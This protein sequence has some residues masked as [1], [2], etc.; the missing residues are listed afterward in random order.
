MIIKRIKVNNY[1]TYLS[2]DLDLSV[3]PDK[4][5]ILIGGDNGGGK[6][7]LF[8]A[9]CGALYGLKIKDRR[10]FN[11]LLNDGGRGKVE[12]KIDLEL[13]FEGIVLGR[14][15]PYVLRRHYEV[16]PSG[17]VVENVRMNMN[18]NVY[19]YG[20][21]TP[22]AERRRNE[23]E[24]SKIIKGNL[25]QELSRYFLFDAMQ[26]SELLKENAFA[27]TIKDNIENV[28]GFNKYL[29]MKRSAEHLL[30]EKTKERLAA[31]E[32]R[33]EYEKLCNSRREL[34]A[35]LKETGE[36]L[37]KQYRY[38]ADMKEA[39]DSAKE[40]ADLIRTNLNE[41]QRIKDQIGATQKQAEA[42]ADGLSAF[43]QHM[44]VN[45]ILP[46]VADSMQ[47]E[48][49]RLIKMKEEVEED[50][51]HVYSLED[52]MTIAGKVV[53]YLKDN[54]GFTL[55]VDLKAMSNQVVSSQRQVL[56]KDEYAYLDKS[57]ANALA[58]LLGNKAINDFVQL[59]K[60]RQTLE[61]YIKNLPNLL[62][63]KETLER[64][65]KGGNQEL[66]K[67]Y[68]DR[69]SKVR[70]LKLT[71]ARTKDEIKKL[72]T[73]INGIDVQMQQEPDPKYDTLVKLVPLFGHITDELLKQKRALIETEMQRQLNMMLNSYK[74]HIGRVEISDSIDNFAIKIYHTAGNEISLDNLNAASKQIFIQVLL[75]VLRNL[76]DYNPPV[77]IDTVMGVLDDTSRGVMMEEYFPKLAEQTILLCTTSEIRKGGENSD[78]DKLKAWC[79]KTYT[80]IRDVEHQN[81]YVQDGYFGVQ[82]END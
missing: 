26:S 82:L 35:T 9:I 8:E 43:V 73:R 34:E 57:E 60:Q 10:H 45:A 72:T 21:F 68:E 75:K 5:I 70:E 52:V 30:E 36:E 59:D 27:Q 38:L 55:P 12:P 76:G 65:S 18:G 63:Q 50:L 48:I 39:Y 19:S 44:E 37:E 81:T 4:P 61:L 79:S 28:M 14:V 11:S 13:T 53:N 23:L 80:L 51:R 64:S 29:Q 67:E 40:G 69:Q 41:I 66:I 22:I 20:T 33:Q 24:V 32:E 78:Y 49:S 42:Y 58:E 17:R 3:S 56:S 47:A 54:Y 62:Q 2:L 15:F 71:E 6:T 46:K 1:K 7:T 77:M 31:Q 74:D 25:P 16:N